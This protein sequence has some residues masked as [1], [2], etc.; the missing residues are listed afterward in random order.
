MTMDLPWL[1]LFSSL[2]T[3]FFVTVTVAQQ[4]PLNHFCSDNSGN[5]TRNSTYKTNLD[6]LLSSFTLNTSNENGFY[7]FSSGQGSNIA[8]ALALCRGDVNSS[9]CFT[10]INNAN[11]ELRNR[12]PYQREAIIWY[13]YCMFRYT[14][15]TILGVA[16]TSPRFYMWNLNNVTNVDAFNQAVS[17]LMDNLTNIASTGT[18]IGKFA[19]GSER[20]PFLTIYALVQ[21]TPDL[22]DTVCKSC[23]SQAIGEIP[24][25]CDRKQGC[26]VYMPSC[27]F[28][29]EIERFYNLT[30]ADTAATPSSP[31]TTVI[32]LELQLSYPFRLLLLL[33]SSFPS[34][35]SLF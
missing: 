27:N 11:D 13:D 28:R 2:T 12:C 5:F 15:R 25:Y 32:H 17:S 20:I 4:E 6:R 30:A 3:A 10:C 23:M 33:Y 34:A 1:F 29:F 16:E 18:S 7:N 8:N 9:D 26:R 14:N 19:T 21:C 35:S 24:N 31:K 22:E